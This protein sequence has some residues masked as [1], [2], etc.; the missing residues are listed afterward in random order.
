MSRRPLSTEVDL[1]WRGR[2]VRIWQ[3]GDGWTGTDTDLIRLLEILAVRSWMGARLRT[4]TADVVV[5][6]AGQVGEVLAVRDP[7]TLTL[8]ITPDRIWQ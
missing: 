1:L 2:P 5:E 6:L 4:C 7:A 3:A 8:P